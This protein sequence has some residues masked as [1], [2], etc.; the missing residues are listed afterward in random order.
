MLDGGGGGGMPLAE[1]PLCYNLV[2]LL[3][4]FH[5]CAVFF[6]TLPP[7]VSGLGKYWSVN[8]PLNSSV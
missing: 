2:T 7:S 3:L 8:I 5:F 4:A 6:P 1:A